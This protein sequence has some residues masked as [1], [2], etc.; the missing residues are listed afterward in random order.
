MDFVKK[1]VTSTTTYLPTHTTR[2]KLFRISLKC[3]D[4]FVVVVDVETKI[5][6][7]YFYKYKTTKR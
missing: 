3:D 4:D 5:I 7:F 1:N 6:N 2:N